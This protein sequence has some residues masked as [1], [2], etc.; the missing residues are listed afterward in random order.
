MWGPVS[1]QTFLGLESKL[2]V[3]WSFKQ[4]KTGAPYSSVWL[5]SCVHA[6]SEFVVY[7]SSQCINVIPGR[8][9]SL[10][11]IFTGDNTK[12][13]RRSNLACFF[14]WD[15]EITRGCSHT[16]PKPIGVVRLVL[17]QQLFAT[18][19]IPLAFKG[20]LEGGFSTKSNVSFNLPLINVG[21]FATNLQKFLFRRRFLLSFLF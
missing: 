20:L 2:P 5:A 21:A 12:L 14:W 1:T 7:E 13:A 4:R 6:V 11:S 16:Q 15:L 19:P 8:T 17:C 10:L 9:T 18:F 3:F